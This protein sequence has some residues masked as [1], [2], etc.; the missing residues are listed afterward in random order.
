[1]MQRYIDSGGQD[2]YL[3]QKTNGM[4]DFK[5]SVK[6]EDRIRVVSSIER[7]TPLTRDEI[8]RMV[9]ERTVIN[10]ST[11]SANY[12]TYLSYDNDGN[13]FET[14]FETG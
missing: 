10:N 14:D 7:G 1:M 11:G 5:T 6:T 12:H 3:F 4:W 9:D 13:Y 8:L 2:Q